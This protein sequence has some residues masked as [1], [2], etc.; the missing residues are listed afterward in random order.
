MIF[1][2][3]LFTY[4]LLYF[5]LF[6]GSSYANSNVSNISLE[7]VIKQSKSMCKKIGY[8]INTQK[9]SDCVLKLTAANSEKI[10]KKKE[11]IKNNNNTQYIFTGEKTFGTK[12]KNKK[13]DKQVNKYMAYPDKNLCI[14]Y[15]NKYGVMFKKTKQ[16]AREEAIRLR[17]LDCSQYRDAA[18]YDKQRRRSVIA[19]ATKKALNENAENKRAIAD[20]YNKNKKQGQRCTYRTIGSTVRKTC[21]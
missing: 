2:N 1:K 17:G 14:G 21:Y 20:S 4:S 7:H 19:D 9:F 3:K 8:K 5:L 12:I 11:A 13:I 6:G 18:F 15:I 16:K 10:I